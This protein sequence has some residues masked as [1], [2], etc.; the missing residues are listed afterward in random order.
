[1]NLYEHAGDQ[2]FDS[3]PVIDADGTLLGVTRMI[4]IT[5]YALLPRT[6]VLRLRATPAPRSTPTPKRAG[7]GVAICYDRHAPGVHAGARRWAAPISSSCPRPA[8]WA[9]GPKVC[10]KPRCG[11]RRFRTGTSWRCATGWDGEDCLEFAG[12]SFVCGP[13]GNGAGAGSLGRRGCG[14]LHRGGRSK[15]TRDSHARQL[16]LRHRRP[17]LYAG[18]IA[19]H[20][21]ARSWLSSSARWAGG[22]S[23][24]IGVN[25]VI[26]AAIFILPADVARLVGPWGP[27]AFLAVG[28]AL[29]L[30]RAVLRRGG[31]PL[32]SDRRPVPAGARRVRPLRRL[33]SRL[34]DVV[35]ARR[36]AR[37]RWPTASH[38]RSRSTG[39]RWP[40]GSGALAVITVLTVT[41]TA[42]N[43]V[44]V[45]Q[46]SWVVNVLTVGKLVPLAIFILAGIWFVDPA[47]WATLPGVTL[48]QVGAAALAADLRLWRIRSDGGAGRGGGRTRSVT[49]RSRSS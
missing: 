47:R 7:I 1:M 37:P 28:A 18:W 9:N 30:H 49:C 16:F 15:A 34:D 35:H 42:I 12:E 41:L 33:R 10:T 29:H 45:K 5:E 38:S 36:R 44:G 20:R 46:S 8:R 48:N 2:C 43:I 23:P 24:A 17:E 27:L 32:R 26:G 13:D 11:W 40:T 21:G 3:S 22:I 6:G 4:H 31:Q 39:R 19:R 25:Q 14:A